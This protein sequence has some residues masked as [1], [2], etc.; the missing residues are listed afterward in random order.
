MDYLLFFLSASSYLLKGKIMK[1]FSIALFAI[2]GLCV[3]MYGIMMEAYYQNGLQPD[4]LVA[5]KEA[6][7]WNLSFSQFMELGLERHLPSVSGN[8]QAL[9]FGLM[10]V[11]PVLAI[12]AVVIRH[13]IKKHLCAQVSVAK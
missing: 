3:T 1:T 2:P 9:G 7:S 8:I 6:I 4:E 5:Y 13:F 10:M 11:P 12:T